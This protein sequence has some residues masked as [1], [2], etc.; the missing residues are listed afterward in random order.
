MQL[1]ELFKAPPLNTKIKLQGWIKSAQVHGESL[2]FIKLND[3]SIYRNIQILFKNKLDVSQLSTGSAIEV[4]GLLVKAKKGQEE[5][6]LL[7]DR[8]EVLAKADEKFPIQKKE[9]TVEFLRENAHQRVRT[10]LFSAINSIKN[11]ISFSVHEFFYKKGFIWVQSPI[12]TTNNCEGGSEVFEIK[13]AIN[14]FK[15]PALLSVS[16][17]FHAEGMA[18][19]LKNVY[20]FG[21]TFRAEKSNTSQHLAEF[22]MI[23][24]ECSFLNLEGNME[25]IEE[26]VKYVTNRVLI[27]KREELEFLA[28]QIPDNE[29]LIVRLENIVNSSFKRMRYKEAI[30]MLQKSGVKFENSEISYGID[31]ASEHEKYIT[32]QLQM[33]VF[34]THYPRNIKAFYMKDTDDKEVLAIDLLVPEVGELIGGSERESDLEKLRNKAIE[35]SIPTEQ[36]EWYLDLRKYGY[37]ASSGYGCGYERLVMYLTG[38]K[39]IKDII[40]YPRSYGQLAF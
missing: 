8:V 21:P 34:I 30:E 23:E 1:R 16:G 22:W 35:F 29:N 36:L 17:Q 5:I 7:A 6:E 9:H 37:Y 19:G 3:G 33:P 18:L 31:L 40:N 26:F 2:V 4:E 20:T 12:L 10:S 27:N 11:E 24:P 28:Q 13:D 32:S 25:L 39:N 38:V 14:I 15:K